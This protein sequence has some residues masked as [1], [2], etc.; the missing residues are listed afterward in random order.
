MPKAPASKF[1][2]HTVLFEGQTGEDKPVLDSIGDSFQIFYKGLTAGDSFKQSV[3]DALA[4]PDMDLEAAK[5]E[6]NEYIKSAP[7][8]IFSWTMSPA[9]KKAKKLLTD[10]GCTYT[11]IELDKPFSKGNPLRAALGRMVGRT[12]VPAIWIGGKYIGGCDDGP[13]VNSPGLI[14]LA[15]SGKLRPMLI[16]AKVMSPVTGI[17]TVTSV[18]VPADNSMTSISTSSTPTFEG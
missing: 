13:D 7:C 18:P 1:C 9:S 16:E 12:S 14:P 8:V 6:I 10:I 5:N 11:A 17:D 4:G 2:A 3:A 15:F